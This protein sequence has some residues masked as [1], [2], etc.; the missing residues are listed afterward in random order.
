MRR[1]VGVALG[2][3][4]LTLVAFTFNTAPLFV[5]GVAFAA[6]G[7]AAPGWV[8]L[9]AR[10]TSVERRLHA[11]RVVEGEPLEATIEVRRG[12]LGLPG[13]ELCD[14]LAQAN[15]ELGVPLSLLRGGRVAHIRIV[16]RFSRRGLRQL[17]PPS[18][19]VHDPLALASVKRPGTGPA[20]ELL[21]LPFTE[22]VRWSLRDGA[23]QRFDGRG[24]TEPLAAV[25]VDGLRPY[26]PGTPASRIHWSSL[27]RGAG[28]LERRLRQD[29]DTRPL[30]VLDARGA[31]PEAHLDAAVRAAASLVLELARRGGARVLLPG[32]RRAVAIES[33]LAGWAAIHARLAMVEGGRGNRAPLL[34]A[35]ARLGP[36]YYVAAQQ[37]RQLPPALVTRGREVVVL[38]LPTPLCS[39]SNGTPTFEVAG[40]RGLLVRGAQ[41]ARHVRAA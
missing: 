41:G 4:M 27:A 37:L 38:V 36:V 9:S 18:L 12:P 7:L 23:P 25:D 8:W 32:E 19:L 16:T 29:A 13:A 5:P 39:L 10:P 30:V 33:D 22:P 3:V 31:G 2:G 26:R 24:P 28:L 21:V 40:C 15:V 14:P 11:D 1:A 17:E 34:D 20:Q 6:I 35:A